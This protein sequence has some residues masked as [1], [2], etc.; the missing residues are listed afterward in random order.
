MG[1]LLIVAV[2]GGSLALGVVL[3]RGGI[4]RTVTW[5]CGYAAPSPRMQYTS[6]S[7]AQMIVG[8]F[9]WFLLPRAKTPKHLDLFPA[10]SRFHS[11]VPDVVLDRA[12]RPAFHLG[13]WCLSWLR[14]VQWGSIQLY[15]LYVFLT[16]IVLLLWS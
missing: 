13:A 4:Q 16:L 8:L 1:V 14:V 10:P 5:D 3:R 11:D 2:V 9:H 15:L 7:F 6:S 12:V